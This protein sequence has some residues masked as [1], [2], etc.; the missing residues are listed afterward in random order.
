MKLQVI[1]YLKPKKLKDVC[2]TRWV[3]RTDSY[4][5]FLDLHEAVH[6]TLDAMVR[7][8]FYT[9]NLGTGWSWDGETV[10]KANGFL[11]QLQSS[12]FLVAFHI[13]LQVMQVLKQLTLKFQMQA[14]DVVYAYKEVHSVL[15][16]LISLRQHSTTEFKKVFDNATKLGRELNGKG[17]ELNKP[18]ITGRQIH[19][20]NPTSCPEDYYRITLYD[21]FL[22]YK[23]VHYTRWFDTI[24]HQFYQ[25]SVTKPSN[26]SI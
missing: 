22:S 14:I 13:L 11:F 5:V 3:E 24:A 6:T 23:F 21:E 16:I 25:I 15:S 1:R 17:F 9:A 12:T 10:T 18:R 19:R 7:P 4:T 8:S 26:F 2:R 20:S